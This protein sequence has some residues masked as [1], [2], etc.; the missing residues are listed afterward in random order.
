M[1]S[2]KHINHELDE[3]IAVVMRSTRTFFPSFTRLHDWFRRKSRMYYRWH[4]MPQST[5]VHLFILSLITFVNLLNFLSFV[6][7][8]PEVAQGNPSLNP[9]STSTS[10]YATPIDYAT[11]PS[12]ATSPTPS[13]DY[14]L[15]PTPTSA[16][17]SSG[18]GGSTPTPTS[19]STSG[20]SSSSTSGTSGESSGSSGGSTG[21]GTSSTSGSSTS[22]TGGSSSQTPGSSVSSSPT[23]R[24]TSSSARPTP[25]STAQ[26]SV[27]STVQPSSSPAT[28]DSVEQSVEEGNS[29]SQLAG[30]GENA[31]V[32]SDMSDSLQVATILNK[33]L[34]KPGETISGYVFIKNL[35]S[36][37][38]T[39]RFSTEKQ[40]SYSILG[41]NLS[42]D[43]AAMQRFVDRSASV[44]I[45]AGASYGWRFS[46]T[47]DR[48]ELAGG[49]YQLKGNVYADDPAI[50]SQI[51]VASFVVSGSATTDASQSGIA[52]INT[53]PETGSK[54]A[55]SQAKVDH[56]S[57]S[58][59][60]AVPVLGSYS[61]S[62][63]HIMVLIL[64]LLALIISFVMNQR[65]FGKR[66]T[67]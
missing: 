29:S 63:L 27:T 49:N 47:P 8:Y 53:T 41:Q 12:D 17:T 34:F 44:T 67:Y 3:Q 35:G 22:T 66:S 23:T 7:A 58:G 45:P 65:L 48:L 6:V 61:E 64:A 5:M 40:A 57:T 25:S 33:K 18:T 15:T 51:S 56:G 32:S 24:R 54:I 9:T 62:Q 31:L 1:S 28:I 52:A 60:S 36:Q 42:Y 21:T 19:T 2:Q 38:K 4:L 14:Y 46:H 10:M 26:S 50:S 55:L 37:P 43:W 39:I 13:F 11:T 20:G 30:D 59:F 16:S